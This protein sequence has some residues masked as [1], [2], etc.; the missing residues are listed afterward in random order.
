ML[1]SMVPVE[2]TSVTNSPGGNPSPITLKKA[3]DGGRPSGPSCESVHRMP[4]A[5]MGAAWV[6]EEVMAMPPASA[7]HST[8]ATMFLFFIFHPF[9]HEDRLPL[10]KDGHN[11]GAP[12]V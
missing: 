2:S 9:S 8:P 4:G 6:G 3:L 1:P 12:P 7:T 11:C 5:G 10:W